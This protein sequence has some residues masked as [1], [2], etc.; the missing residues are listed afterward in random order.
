MLWAVQQ[1]SAS[2][3]GHS[4]IA[5]AP[6]D[7]PRMWTGHLH[8]APALGASMWAVSPP[9]DLDHK[10]QNTV[11]RKGLACVPT[12]SLYAQLLIFGEPFA[13]THFLMKWETGA[14]MRCIIDRIVIYS[15]RVVSTVYTISTKY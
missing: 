1:T 15:S 11:L 13:N 4:T 8:L 7:L 12:A 10:G 9:K 6:G 5:A 2:I 3:V 14:Q